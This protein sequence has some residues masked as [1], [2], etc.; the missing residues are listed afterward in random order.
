VTGEEPG[1]PAAAEL[2]A[3]G[4]ESSLT[5]QVIAHSLML[6][7]QNAVAYQQMVNTVTVAI[8]AQVA[9]GKVDPEAAGLR[10]VLDLLAA[11][12]PTRQ[13]EELTVLL[14]QVNGPPA[15]PPGQSSG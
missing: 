13:L 4:T 7:M 15:A 10:A 9:T 11:Q 14:R 8:A 2:P 5:H 3:A 12:N 6:A 1:K